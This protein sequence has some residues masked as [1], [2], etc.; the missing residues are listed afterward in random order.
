MKNR[1]A[2]CFFAACARTC[3]ALNRGTVRC[4]ATALDLAIAASR[5]FDR[6]HYA[7][8]RKSAHLNLA[9]INERRG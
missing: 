3:A 5:F 9:I 6:A 4:T 7:A 8:T 1:L 2:F